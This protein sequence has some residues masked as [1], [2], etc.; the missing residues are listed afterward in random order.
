MGGR[1]ESLEVMATLIESH[2]QGGSAQA[3]GAGGYHNSFVLADAGEAWHLE[4]VNRRWVA[5]RVELESISN[6]MSI[7]SGWEIA[8]RDFESFARDSGLWTG[9][10]RL[11][12]AAAY[13]DRRIPDHISEGRCHRAAQLLADGR[14]SHD[15]ASFQRILRDHGAGGEV[16]RD[17]GA[18]VDEER[19]FT[20]CAHSEP[21]H[22]TTASIVVPLPLDCDRPWPVW[23]SFG[24]PC[25]GI[26]LP[27]YL[28]GVVPA[29]LARGGD[30]PDE[31]SA[32]WVFKEL[33]N[34]ASR[35]P[36]RHTPWLREQWQPLESRIEMERGRMEAGARRALEDGDG[37]LAAELASRFMSQSVEA[38]LD[39]ARAL[40]GQLL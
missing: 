20:L 34:A 38:A 9:Q 40:R 15:V 35:D 26:F 16:W 8:S 13:R 5:R 22:W 37:D 31:S 18:R 27:V 36:E 25:T 10:G 1:F 11:D 19:L 12:A 29:P 33:Q 2:G 30:E 39:L 7:G 4:A 21:V 6:H 32:W 17:T 3:P 24:T 14:G 28:L 23:V